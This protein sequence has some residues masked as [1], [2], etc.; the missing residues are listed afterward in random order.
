MEEKLLEWIRENADTE[1]G[2]LHRFHDIHSIADYQKYVPLSDYSD[3]EDAIRRM[4]AGKSNVLTAYP[5]YCF[6]TTSGSV[7]KPKKIPLTREGLRPFAGIYDN[8][9]KQIGEKSGK[10]IHLSIFPVDLDGEEREMML[11]AAAYRYLYER[12]LFDPGRYVG[13][14]ECLFSKETESSLYIKLWCALG[15]ENLLSIQSIFLYDVLL[16]FAYLREHGME[17]L[18]AM[19]TG[20]IPGEIKLTKEMK[21]RLLTSLRPSEERI[22]FLKQELSLGLEAIAPRIWKQLHMISGI[23]GS[24]F[25]SRERLLRQY[26]GSVPWQ[27]FLYGSSECLAAYAEELERPYYTLI[28][29]S[30]YF[31]FLDRDTGNVYTTQEVKENQQYELVITNRSGLY[32]YRQGD[33]VRIQG[34]RNR[35]PMLEILGRINQVLNVAGEKM[36]AAMLEAAVIRFSKQQ[37]IAFHDYAVAAGESGFPVGYL[38]YLELERGPVRE[39]VDE[40]SHSFDRVLREVNPDYDDLRNLGRLALPRIICLRKGELE[41]RKKYRNTSQNKPGQPILQK[42]IL[43]K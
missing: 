5:V 1:F 30:G 17:M 25:R 31:E 32:R 43:L 13:G 3:Y 8:V 26:T 2:K 22:R 37:G 4:Y 16:F 40:M 14:K 21:A 27:Y 20:V 11:T 38:V 19:E 9:M 7:G 42:P 12:K 24:F 36:N 23:G 41:R 29:E 10:H 28:P 39:T 33:L 6:V 15:E 35:I 34:F 18:S